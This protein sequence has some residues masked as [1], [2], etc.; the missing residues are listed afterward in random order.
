MRLRTD[1]QQM[2]IMPIS[3]VQNTDHSLSPLSNSNPAGKQTLVAH[4]IRQAPQH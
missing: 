2:A 3:R 4:E 1:R